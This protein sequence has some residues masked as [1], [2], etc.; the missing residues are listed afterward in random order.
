VLP[1]SGRFAWENAINCLIS[2][3]GQWFAVLFGLL[4]AAVSA[5]QPVAVTLYAYHDKPPYMTD[6]LRQEGQYYD[7]VRFLNAQSDDYQFTLQ[8]MPRNRVERLL[9]QGALGGP[10]IGVNPLWFKDP[11]EQRYLWTQA[12]FHDQDVFVSPVDKPFDYESPST[13]H[14][15]MVCLVLGNYYF[16]ISEA[17]EKGL[18]RRLAANREEVILEMLDLKRCDFG[19]ISLSLFHYHQNLTQWRQHYHLASKPHDSFARR[20]LV[21]KT[22]PA[23][24]AYLQAQLPRWQIPTNGPIR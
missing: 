20:I 24:H 14:G 5:A 1:V 8:F 6:V 18:L 7:L 21:P 10:V 11:Q 19:V 17:I 3:L 13:L 15:K 9:A 4:M 22:Q 16:G 12:I 2:R 23:L